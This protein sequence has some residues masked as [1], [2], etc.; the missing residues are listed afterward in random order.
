MLSDQERESYMC[1]QNTPLPSNISILPYNRQNRWDSLGKISSEPVLVS[2]WKPRWAPALLCAAKKPPLLPPL[3]AN[4]ACRVPVLHFP[5]PA[6]FGENL[7]ISTTWKPLQ[8][9]LLSSSK[10]P[11]S[12][13]P[14]V[15][16]PAKARRYSH[17]QAT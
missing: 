4:E 15:L 11:N 2:I 12:I 13:K 1:V 3:K 17:L 16:E 7:R 10:V 6:V 14:L 5:Q 8:M 9:C